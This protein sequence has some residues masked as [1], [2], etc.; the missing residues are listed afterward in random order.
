M[1]KHIRSHTANSGK[2]SR[3]PRSP[4]KS[5]VRWV[6][7]AL[8]GGT[9]PSPPRRL[10]FEAREP[11]LLLSVT[12][13]PDPVLFI[14]GFG[15]TEPVDTSPAGMQEWLTTRGIAPEK[16]QNET[17]RNGYGDIAQT[18]ENVGYSL[19]GV[20]DGKTPFYIATWDWR[21]PVAPA[22]GTADGVINGVAAQIA[23]N[24]S[25]NPSFQSGADYL[26][27]WLKR[28]ADDW[29]TATGTQLQKV[30]IVAHSTGGLVARSYIES[31]AYG[32]GL[33]TVD[34]LVLAGVPNEG[35]SFAFNLLQNDWSNKPSTRV[36]GQI[37]NQAWNLMLGGKN[38]QGPDGDV[39]KAS[40]FT[41]SD[42]AA[43]QR[44]FIDRY[45]GTLQDLVPDYNFLDTDNDGIF[46]PAPPA[47]QNNLLFDLNGAANK[48]AFVDRTTQTT[49]VYSSE[50][51]TETR[52][53]LKSGPDF[54][55][56]LG[57]EILPFT[58]YFGN[59]PASGQ[60]WS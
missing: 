3:T 42:I 60:S 25:A 6:S 28:A 22:D 54:S 16:L 27:Y 46:E 31:D 37:V 10:H 48:D 52:V 44:S 33:P 19:N 5:L 32:A 21:V 40:D 17:L 12:P 45:V 23:D 20:E 14:P 30:D 18:L 55:L 51:D 15:A 34:Q 39:I 47:F 38:I 13:G 7:A 29:F 1:S 8:A 24:G 26:G 59:I 43:D 57:N 50:A 58:D 9:A 35:V 41:F 4:L 2:A 11:R 56:G 53:K 36:L 49:V